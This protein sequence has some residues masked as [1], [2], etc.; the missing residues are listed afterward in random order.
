MT[1][2]EQQRRT[3]A[4]VRVMPLWARPGTGQ[5]RA[6]R[7]TAQRTEPVNILQAVAA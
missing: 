1:T 2:T 5:P 3:A 4:A 7:G 6:E